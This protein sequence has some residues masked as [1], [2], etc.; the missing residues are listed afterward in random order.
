MLELKKNS[1]LFW[2]VSINATPAA[3]R[4]AIPGN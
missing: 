2:A 1:L 4:F 3:R